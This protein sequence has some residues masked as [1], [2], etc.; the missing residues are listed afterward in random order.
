MATEEASAVHRMHPSN[1]MY[2]DLGMEANKS[3]YIIPI[4]KIQGILSKEILLERFAKTFESSTCP[5]VFRSLVED[6][7]PCPFFKPIDNFKVEN[8]MKFSDVNLN[9]LKQDHQNYSKEDQF[10]SDYIRDL[11]LQPLT[12]DKPL[13]EAHIL[14]GTTAESTSFGTVII[15][16]IHHSLGDGV[17]MLQVLRSLADDESEK[18]LMLETQG[19][20][21][22][23]P[24]HTWSWLKMILVIL[25][26]I[27]C[28]VR[29]ILTMV[30]W[31]NGINKSQRVWIFPKE[32]DA[33]SSNEL[34]LLAP[35]RLPKLSQVRAV[36]K[37]YKVTVNDLLLAVYAAALKKYAVLHHGC[38]TAKVPDMM[39]SVAVAA[40]GL[41]TLKH[42]KYDSNFES[43]ICSVPGFMTLPVSADSMA[44]R[45]RL[46]SS[47]TGRFKKSIATLVM[48]P[49]A[50][51][52]KQARL[53]LAKAVAEGFETAT[54]AF[55]NLIGPTHAIKLCG[56]KLGNINHVVSKPFFDSY[57]LSSASSSSTIRT[58]IRSIQHNWHCLIQ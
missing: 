29:M 19:V 44:D 3:S 43:V 8:Q 14:R 36:A 34:S 15:F 52:P 1:C 12:L 2:L 40:H 31:V 17:A 9:E 49:S 18:H 5:I 30:S 26:S 58:D 13:W 53:K 16:K 25:Y 56:S 48:L 21:R 51:M 6:A 4:L 35:E 46:V 10:I 37:R 50:D 11:T 24:V 41:R 32:R 27:Y 45:L 33:K 39:F 20:S 28:G 47:D 42:I 57:V 23:S 22:S 7:D 54:A 38:A 55:S